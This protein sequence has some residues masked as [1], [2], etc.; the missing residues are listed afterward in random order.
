TFLVGFAAETSE[1]ETHARE[2]L[3]RK[4]LDAIAVNDV[5]V[6]GS[7]FGRGPS[8]LVLL[9]PGGGRADLGHA[10]KPELAARLWDALLR[11]RAETTT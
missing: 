2:K 9:W 8:D 7:G 3:V 6:E 5:S 10:S 4:H 11:V 1:I